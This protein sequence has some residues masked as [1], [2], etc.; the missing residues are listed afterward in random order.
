V[1]T[2]SSS[3]AVPEF[4]SL[5][6]IIPLIVSLFAVAAMLRHKKK[7]SQE[8]RLCEKPKRPIESFKKPQILAF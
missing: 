5:L 2:A 8:R 3:P 4:P 6:F 1:P 7:P